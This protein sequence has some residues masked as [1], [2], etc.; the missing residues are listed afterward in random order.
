MLPPAPLE[1]R[2]VTLDLAFAAGE[3]FETATRPFIRELGLRLARWIDHHPHPAW[4]EYQG[5][6]RFLLVDKAAA[7]ACPQLITPELVEEI[8]PVEHLFAHADFDGMLSAAKFLNGGHEPYPEADEDGRAI[9]APG[10]GYVCSER[11][12]RLALAM[13]RSG[14]AHRSKHEAFAIELVQALVSGVEPP[15]LTATIDRYAAQALQRQGE[16]VGLVEGAEQVHPQI[17]VLRLPRTVSAADKKTLLRVMEERVTLA[18]IEEPQ[19]LTAATY[20]GRLRLTEVSKLHGTDGFAWG[21]ARYDDVHA[22][23]VAMVEALD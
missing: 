21:R 18:L 19:A 15:E 14:D 16:L 6:P 2:V 13:E 3:W 23:V 10:Q 9:D 17:M 5:D 8:G 20:D 4:E 12:M 7:P 11:G 1:G 22:E